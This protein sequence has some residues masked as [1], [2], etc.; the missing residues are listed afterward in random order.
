M[1]QWL[2]LGLVA[3]RHQVVEQLMFALGR[4][5]RVSANNGLRALA[6]LLLVP[7]GHALAG[8]RGA[9]AAVVLS[10]FAGWP[11]SVQFQRQ[12]GLWRWRSEAGWLAALAAGLLLG[13]AID[14]GLRQLA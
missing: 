13:A 5:A 4:P 14:A 1:L 2:G 9:V 7:A 6:L 8:E 11:A 10:Q 3:L 12:Q